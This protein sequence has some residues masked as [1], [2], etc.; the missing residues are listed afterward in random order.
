M[1]TV[2]APLLLSVYSCGTKCLSFMMP[3][4]K[5]IYGPVISRKDERGGGAC[6]THGSYEKFLQNFG[7]KN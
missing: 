5:Y 4:L 7:R 2:S 6:S 1:Q 3:T